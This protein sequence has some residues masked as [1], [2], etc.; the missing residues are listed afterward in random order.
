MCPAPN[1]HKR[2]AFSMGSVL[3]VPY[4]WGGGGV[5]REYG[6]HYVGII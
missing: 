2:K 4:A 3:G 6:L 1:L 5:D